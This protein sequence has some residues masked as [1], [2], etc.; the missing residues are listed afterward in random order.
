MEKLQ[1]KITVF[2]FNIFKNVTEKLNF[3]L[4]SSVS[5]DPSEIFL[6]Y[7]FAAVENIYAALY[8]CGKSCRDSLN[9]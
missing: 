1:F 7:W 8:F 5:H 9:L 4:Q 3:L 6:I 2:Y